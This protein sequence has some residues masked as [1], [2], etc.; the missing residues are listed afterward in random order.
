MIHTHIINPPNKHQPPA[1]HS[2]P[3]PWVA[4]ETS[5]GGSPL[6]GIAL[7][8]HVLQAEGGEGMVRALPELFGLAEDQDLGAWKNAITR[9]NKIIYKS[10]Y[11]YIYI[12]IWRDAISIFIYKNISYILYVMH[13]IYYMENI[14]YIQSIYSCEKEFLTEL[15]NQGEKTKKNN[16]KND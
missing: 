8:R 2:P 5:D 12:Y 4:V 14:I 3:R 9:G 10:I 15:Q 11:I 1:H 13:I 6:Q 7:Q 16:S